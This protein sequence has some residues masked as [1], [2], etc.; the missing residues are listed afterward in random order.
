MVITDPNPAPKV[1]AGR[2]LFN[3]SGS[4]ST[5]YQTVFDT[6]V[7]V[8]AGHWTNIVI[9]HSGQ[10]HGNVETISKMMAGPRGLPHHFIIGNGNG[11][12]DG[13][14][15]LSYR[16]NTQSSPA[17]ESPPEVPS[18]LDLSRSI[19]I[20]LVGNGDAH[21]FTESQI[22]R[23]AALIAGLKRELNIAGSDV[24]L[25][26]DFAVSSGPGPRFDLTMLQSQ[27]DRLEQ[28]G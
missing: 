24:R 20:C 25:G 21:P 5:S 4:S 23:L 17:L 26:T 8:D 22:N 27:V 2:S 9:E 16:W 18:E 12:G 3:I 7:P 11:M 28:N 13:D 15:H 14:L 6:E 10:P 19:R 1:A